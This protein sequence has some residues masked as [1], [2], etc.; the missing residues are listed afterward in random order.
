M[1][2][3]ESIYSQLVGEL[4]NQP[5]WASA[6]RLTTSAALPL[7]LQNGFPVSSSTGS[8]GTGIITNTFAV[9]PNYNVGYA[10]VWNLSTETALMDNTSLV[11]TYTGTK[12]TGLDMLFAFNRS[13]QSAS[14]APFTVPNAGTFTYDTTGG[15]SIYNA[16]QVRLQ[17]RMSHGMMFNAIYTYGKSIDDASSIGGGSSVVVQNPEDI[18]AE[19]G[20][21]SFDIRHQLRAN[22]VY[23]LPFGDGHRFAQKGFASAAFGNWRFSGN[24][25]AQTGTPFTAKVQGNSLLNTGG[26]GAF[27]TR[28]NQT[29][30]PNLP[31]GQ[32]TV[33]NFFN[34][35]CFTVPSG[36]FGDAA[37]NTI[38]GPGMFTWNAQLAKTIPFG[39]D[40]NRRIDVRLEITN[41]TN[42]PHFTGLSTVVGSSTFGQITSAGG[43]RTMDIMTRVNF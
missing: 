5:P 31:S 8:S 25:A 39:R 11:I 21:S 7:T 35:S 42:T 13:G 27:A 22:Y 33:L 17:H 15:N 43:N 28:A 29:C 3:N 38:I 2:Y 6:L 9:N 16:L 18:R 40:R 10:Q 24:I 37:R 26:G 14:G 12:G 32:Q 23:A 30:D 36:E 41:L 1:L 34:T 20:L 4:A 19:Y